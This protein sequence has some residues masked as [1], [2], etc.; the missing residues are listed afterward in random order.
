MNLQPYQDLLAE[1]AA[2]GQHYDQLIARLQERGATQMECV[3][4]LVYG[5]ELPL[6]E[7]DL[8]VLNAPAWK[9]LLPQNI[10]LRDAFWD[11]E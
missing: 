9:E 8:L 10:R 6:R 3:K 2:T 4:V 5:C 7:A 1:H 11:S